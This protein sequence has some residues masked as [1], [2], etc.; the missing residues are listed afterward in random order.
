MNEP[1]SLSASID[2]VVP[3]APPLD[4]SVG[5]TSINAYLTEQPPPSYNACESDLENQPPSY[6]SLFGRD[7]EGIQRV[8]EVVPSTP[9]QHQNTEQR[10][11]TFQDEAVVHSDLD[12]WNYGAQG[13]NLPST[14]TGFE[15]TGRTR[16]EGESPWIDFEFKCKCG[17]DD[18]RKCNKL[19]KCIFFS[20]FI[21]GIPTAGIALGSKY[22]DNCQ[23]EPFI[24]IWLMIFGIGSLF[25]AFFLL[26]LRGLDKLRKSGYRTFYVSYGRHFNMVAVVIFVF[27]IIWF[28][29]G[30]VFVLRNYNRFY[31]ATA[32]YNLDCEKVV[33]Q[34][35]IAWIILCHISLGILGLML[36]YQYCCR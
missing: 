22:I 6:N 4:P 8:E 14:I 12:D 20:Q 16:R 19:M 5:E 28:I 33:F 31:K 21:V 13:S 15:S 29:C 32:I 17:F 27:L 18:D 3:S 34:F 2:V 23:Q 10:Q 9:T 24:P 36:F 35:A 25:V 7:M 1:T 30:N 11:V 26:I